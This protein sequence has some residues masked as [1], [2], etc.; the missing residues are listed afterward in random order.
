MR[1]VAWATMLAVKFGREVTSLA[2]ED[3]RAASSRRCV[4]EGQ[5]T[6]KPRPGVARTLLERKARVRSPAEVP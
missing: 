2:G 6:G 3:W 5:G 4:Q 1:V